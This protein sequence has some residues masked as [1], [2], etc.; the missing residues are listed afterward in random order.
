MKKITISLVA[1][2]IWVLISGLSYAQQQK[3]LRVSQALTEPATIDPHMHHNVETEDITR[4]ICEHLIE[5][6]PDG[7]LIPSLATG[8]QLIDENTWQFKLRKGVRFHNGEEFDAEAVKFSI[9]RII[10]PN[11]RSPQKHWYASI[12]Q[13]EIIDNHTIN[14]ITKG[15]DVL[16]PAKLGSFLGNVV[17][18]RYSKEV[19]EAEFG[20]HPIGTGPFKFLSLKRGGEIALVPN[21]KYWGQVPKID[22]LEF[23]FIPDPQKQIEMLV[24]GDLDIVSNIPPRSSLRLK[25][26]PNTSLVKK[27]TL[28]YMSSRMNTLKGGPLSDPRVRQSIN[29]AIDVDK[30]IKYVFNGNG[31]KLATITMP[32]EFGFHPS[33]KPY[34]Y[35][36]QFAKELLKKAGYAG[37]IT[38]DFIVF[39][40]LEDLGK[41]IE[42]ELSRVGIKTKTKLISREDFIKEST[43]K[44][45]DYDITLGNPTDPYFDASFQLNLMFSSKGSFS[46]Y[47]NK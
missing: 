42:K 8:W 1:I 9:D 18:V 23:Y 30:L 32:E 45:L 6:D 35:D 37:G 16:L 47:Q 36:P 28:Q 17:P 40:D 15:I 26:D 33:L 22:R 2:G 5:R 13:A 20:R 3:V 21:E 12:S 25:Q 31:K 29:Y 19:G 34:P 44:T 24:N 4:Q 43:N 14:I 38:L 11:R 41:A 7:K 46:V 39:N 27:A 10:D